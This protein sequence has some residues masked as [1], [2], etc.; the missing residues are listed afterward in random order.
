MT[1]KQFQPHFLNRFLLPH[2]AT[3]NTNYHSAICILMKPTVHI[4]SKLQ[5]MHTSTENLAPHQPQL[6]TKHT[7]NLSR[8]TRRICLGKKS[9]SG[10][11][12][13]FSFNNVSTTTRSSPH[14]AMAMHCATLHPQVCEH[15]KSTQKDTPRT[16]N[17]TVFQITRAATAAYCRYIYLPAKVVPKFITW[18][19]LH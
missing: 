15:A 18:R 8:F 1:T 9:S 5:Q 2:M 12:N 7:S 6:G 17:Q 14:A 10:N 13:V 3:R 16:Q 19:I 4:I 11:Q